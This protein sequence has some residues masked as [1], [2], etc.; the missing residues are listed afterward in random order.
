MNPNDPMKVTLIHEYLCGEAPM[1][2]HDGAQL[3]AWLE[4]V[5]AYE[6]L[7]D[8]ALAALLLDK[9]WAHLPLRGVPNDLVAEA[10]RR[11]RGTE[12]TDEASH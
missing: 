12:D 7:S 3:L 9:V 6:D 4:R 2:E 5:E 8:G 11:L 10:I 1:N